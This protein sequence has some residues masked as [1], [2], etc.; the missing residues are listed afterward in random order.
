[1]SDKREVEWV[2]ENGLT[3]LSL[4]PSGAI[5]PHEGIPLDIYD[6]II[7]NYPNAPI[8]TKKALYNALW[9][10]GIRKPT[11]FEKRNARQIIKQAIQSACA[12]DANRIIKSIERFNEQ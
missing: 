4:I 11:D 3:R 10:R 2:D 1:M 5:N 12:F 9:A 6:I 8:E 7:E